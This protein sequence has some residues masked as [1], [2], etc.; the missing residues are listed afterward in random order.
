MTLPKRIFLTGVPGSRWS[1]IAQII[2]EQVPGFN[3]TDRTPE[4][5]YTHHS[6]SGH[7]GAY[8]GTGMEF[9]PNC[10]F[11]DEAWQDPNAGCMIV[12]S[13]EWAHDLKG[14][15]IYRTYKQGDWI[16][17]VYRPDMASYAWWHEAGGFKITYP[18]YDWYQD[19]ANMLTE[20]QRQNKKILEFAYDVDAKWS[21][22][23]STW[24]EETFGHKVEIPD[25]WPDILVTMVK[26]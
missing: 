17:L 14:I 9:E 26:K 7:K 10:S 15:H 12:K 2:E 24:V 20:I 1:G 5:D 8:F 19:S 23:S 6:Y 16:M 3:T 4:R 22:F 13:H 18:K 11:T 21:H 25:I